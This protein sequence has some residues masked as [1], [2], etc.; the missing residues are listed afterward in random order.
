T[1]HLVGGRRGTKLTETTK[2]ARHRAACRP[3]TP[4]T[5]FGQ[6]VT[7]TVGRRTAVAVAS[8]GIILRLGASSPMAAPAAGTTPVRTGNLAAASITDVATEDTVATNAT[9]SVDADVSWNLGTNVEVESEAPPPP[10]EPE[11]EPEPEVTYERTST[12]TSRSNER[13]ATA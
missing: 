6:A 1:A 5:T 3:A 12:Q 9:I 11:P 4:L 2:T 7:G 10:P 13:T 8:S